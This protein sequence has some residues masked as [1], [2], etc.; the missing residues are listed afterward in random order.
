[1]LEHSSRTRL[2]KDSITVSP[3]LTGRKV[4]DTDLI[5]AESSQR[6]GDELGTVVSPQH[7]RW[8]APDANVFSNAV[9][10]SFAR[11]EL[12]TMLGTD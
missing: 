1:M 9:T 10:R 4:A 5:L 8:A 6:F 2:L 3:R 12:S 11:M 7:V